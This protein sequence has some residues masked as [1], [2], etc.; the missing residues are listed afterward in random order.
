MFVQPTFPFVCPLGGTAKAVNAIIPRFSH[1]G[2]GRGSRFI[3]PKLT[4]LIKVPELGA[5]SPV[6]RQ[7]SPRGCS[8]GGSVLAARALCFCSFSLDR[9]VFLCLYFSWLLAELL[10]GWLC[11]ILHLLSHAYLQR[12]C[13][14]P[15]LEGILMA[16]CTCGKM[17]TI[18]KQ[19][20]LLA[21]RCLSWESFKLCQGVGIFKV[22]ALTWGK[23]KRSKGYN[24]AD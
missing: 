10:V 17:Q 9:G 23:G 18:K 2:W 16:V 8:N 14:S 6:E 21:M 7:S 19:K 22:Y 12:W 5:C 3:P 20:R 11:L 1:S 4:H 15:W 13:L 24:F